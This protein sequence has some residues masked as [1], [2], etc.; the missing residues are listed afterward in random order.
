[1]QKWWRRERVVVASSLVIISQRF[2]LLSARAFF[3]AGTSVWTE[4]M[5][6]FGPAKVSNERFEELRAIAAV[7]V[8]LSRVKL[9]SLDIRGVSVISIT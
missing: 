2:T 5:V 1:M 4:E 7:L 3:K 8:E 6:P 9:R